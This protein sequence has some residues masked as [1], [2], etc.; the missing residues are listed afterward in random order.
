MVLVVVVGDRAS[1]SS[2]W[3]HTHY[4]VEEK[5]ELLILPLPPKC[6]DYI[7]K[8]ISLC[9]MQYCLHFMAVSA[10]AE[11]TTFASCLD[12]LLECHIVNS[13]T[14]GTSSPCSATLH[15]Q[16]PWDF[17]KDMQPAENYFLSK[18][19]RECKCIKINHLAPIPNLKFL[20]INRNKYPTKR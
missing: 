5:P 13:L 8:L 20:W 14:H 9:A 10:S 19:S 2:N 16:R 7:L 3:P 12:R 11:C 1:L 17:T 18:E 4:V 15:R 6:R